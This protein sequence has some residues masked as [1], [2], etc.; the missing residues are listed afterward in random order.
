MC[1]KQCTK[2]NE[3]KN[4]EDFFWKSK[5]NGK[6]HSQ[7]KECYREAR[8]GGEHYQMYKEEYVARAKKRKKR[9]VE[10]NREKLREYFSKHTCV[11]CPETD[12]IVLEFDHLIR[13][14]KKK[15]ISKMMQDYTWE[16]IL[17]E[18]DKCEVVCANCHKRRTAKQFGW[19]KQ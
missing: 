3:Q 9:L 19:W 10:E 6:R 12:P 5:V 8:K 11:D 18:I 15:G 7:C 14:D 2:C 4:E 13:E 16:Q 1:K 17:L